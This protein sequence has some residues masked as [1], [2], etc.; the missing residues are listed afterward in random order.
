VPEV[1]LQIVHFT[2]HGSHKWLA[3]LANVPAGQTKRH[4][5]PD[6]YAWFTP[7]VVHEEHIVPEVALQTVHFTSH[8]SHKWLAILANFPVRQTKTHDDPDKYA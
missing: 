4:D 5:V 1:A 6:K 8:G 2:S 7:L 3:E